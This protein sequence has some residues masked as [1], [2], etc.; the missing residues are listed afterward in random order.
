MQQKSLWQ[1]FVSC[2]YKYATFNGRARRKE[3]W[4]FVLFQTIISLVFL[5]PMLSSIDF[6]TAQIGGSYFLFAGLSSLFSLVSFLPG[7]AVTV[8]RLHDLGKG[9]GWIFISLIPLV[10][11]ILLLVWFF[12]EGER[13]ENRFGQDPK[14]DEL[15][16]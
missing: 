4:S 10:G 14:L 5:I 15:S 12:T 16:Y 13:Q 9:G 8:R 11:S 6:E 2:W 1:H 7:L 3:Y